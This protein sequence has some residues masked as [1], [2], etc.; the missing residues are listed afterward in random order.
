VSTG[1]LRRP[2]ASA[3]PRRSTAADQPA[4]PPTT[5]VSAAAGASRLHIKMSG[6]NARAVPFLIEYLY[7]SIWLP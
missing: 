5:T 7:L 3:T 4:A 6:P 2:E 1:R